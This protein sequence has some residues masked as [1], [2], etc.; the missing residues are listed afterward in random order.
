[1]GICYQRKQFFFFSPFTVE[2]A[3]TS[4]HLGQQRR[5]AALSDEVLETGLQFRLL[6]HRTSLI[7]KSQRHMPEETG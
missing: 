1:M 2:E 5:S 3:Q 7:M 4:P 6:L